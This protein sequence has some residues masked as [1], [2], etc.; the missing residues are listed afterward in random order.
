MNIKKEYVRKTKKQKH[1]ILE[2][3]KICINCKYLYE[4]QY[5]ID[6]YD[7]YCTHPDNQERRYLGY[8]PIDEEDSCDKW[9]WNEWQIVDPETWTTLLPISD[10]EE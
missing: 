1:K 9:K 10:Y 3:C 8:R 4:H 5:E 6:A 2:R 7:T